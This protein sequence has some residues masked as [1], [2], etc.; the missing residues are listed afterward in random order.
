MT[1]CC[2]LAFVA[3]ALLVTGCGTSPAQ[4]SCTITANVTPV[5]ATAD[6]NATPP[7][8]QM[9]FA[10]NTDVQG[11]CP[12]AADVAGTWSTSDPANTSV[13]Q[14]GLATCLGATTKPATISNSG[15]VRHVKSFAPAAL[16]CH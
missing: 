13:N 7:G 1:R 11:T 8:N 4:T 10:L 3:C 12:A 9:Q 14:Q 2:I 15:M 5:N 6:H 16:T